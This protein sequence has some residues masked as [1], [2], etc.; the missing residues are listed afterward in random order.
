[1]ENKRKKSRLGTLTVTLAAKDALHLT[2]N[3]VLKLK[4]RFGTLKRNFTGNRA[5]HFTFYGA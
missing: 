3:G 5:L 2:F 1:M 4:S